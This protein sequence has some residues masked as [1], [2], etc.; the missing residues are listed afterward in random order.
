MKTKH[1]AAAAAAAKRHPDLSNAER[2]LEKFWWIPAGNTSSSSSCQSGSVEEGLSSGGLS[3]CWDLKCVSLRLQELEPDSLSKTKVPHNHQR[4]SCCTWRHGEVV[5]GGAAGHGA[6]R[7]NAFLL[8]DSFC[9]FGSR[10]FS[11]L[12]EATE[13]AETRG[14]FSTVLDITPPP[15]PLCFVVKLKFLELINHKHGVLSCT[16][17]RDSEGSFLQRETRSWIL[18]Y[19]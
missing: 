15:R 16:P 5:D 1:A 8:G 7:G 17:S 10:A 13:A 2:F 19:C 14:R 9:G 12:L 11:H 6:W 4:R 3:G 18:A